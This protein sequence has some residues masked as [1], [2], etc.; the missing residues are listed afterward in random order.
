[1][2]YTLLLL[3]L[4]LS[5]SLDAE[6]RGLAPIFNGKN[7]SG[8]TQKGGKAKYTI[9]DGNI[10]GTAAPNTPNSFLCTQKIYADFI[11][12]YEYKCDNRLNSGVQI[13]SNAYD[14]EVTKKLANGKIKKFPAGRVHGYQVEIDPN[15]PSRMWSAGIYD[16]G[17]RGWLYPGLGGG[18]GPA[19]TK[20]GQ[21]IYK[22]DK[23]NKVRVECRGDSIKTWLNGV[24]RADVKDGLTSKGFI[25]LQVHGIGGKKD[26]VGAQVQWRNLRLKELK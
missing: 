6:E 12:E 9:E 15:K 14:K 20:A 17:R 26:L 3:T 1:M 19:F 2:K 4:A 22:P 21:K 25:G 16:E 5:S 18:D 8:W 10:V 11:L 7:L 23:W 13:R 24:A